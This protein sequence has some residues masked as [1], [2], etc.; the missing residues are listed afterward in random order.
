MAEY[1]EKLRTIASELEPLDWEEEEYVQ[2]LI[3]VASTFRP[4]SDAISLFIQGHGYTGDLGDTE[5]KIAYISEKFE[6]EEIVFEK[7]NIK[8]WFSE[9]SRIEKETGY[10][11]C[12]AFHLN[13][14]ERSLLKPYKRPASL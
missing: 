9:G 6:I 14:E 1:T 12:F 2:K 7:R 5:C 10:L 3:D 11:F 13:V 8:K 4:F